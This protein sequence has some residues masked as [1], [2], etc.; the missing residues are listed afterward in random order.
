MRSSIHKYPR[1]GMAYYEQCCVEAK[2]DSPLLQEAEDRLALSLTLLENHSVVLRDNNVRME[3]RATSNYYLGLIY[4]HWKKDPETA[5]NYFEEA[6]NSKWYNTYISYRACCFAQC[7][8]FDEAIKWFNLINFTQ[9]Q[10]DTKAFMILAFAQHLFAQKGVYSKYLTEK[11]LN[12]I[13]EN[14]L[15]DDEIKQWFHMLKDECENLKSIADEYVGLLRVNVE[16]L[17]LGLTNM[18]KNGLMVVKRI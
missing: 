1:S 14:E 18:W 5:G 8:Q 2:E 13:D 7:N 12:K 3:F 4:K 15:E 17:N 16:L 9:E 10:P 11:Y 6:A